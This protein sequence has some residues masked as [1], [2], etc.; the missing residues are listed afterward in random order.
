MSNQ[1]NLF[2]TIDFF[3]EDVPAAVKSMQAFDD[4]YWKNCFDRSLLT[5]KPQNYK[6]PNC[7]FS[8]ILNS[9]EEE[10]VIQDFENVLRQIPFFSCRFFIANEQSPDEKLF[11]YVRDL[12]KKKITKSMNLIATSDEVVCGEIMPDEL[13]Q[14][15]RI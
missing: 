11:T 8:L 9:Y 1:L 6:Y 10:Q 2:G 5:A 3:K 7:S 12:Q 15:T 13:I 14:K 4:T